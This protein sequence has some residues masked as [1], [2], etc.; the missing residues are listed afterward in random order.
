[1]ENSTEK[2]L[3]KIS[4]QLCCITGKIS[5]EESEVIPPTE[6]IFAPSTS[7]DS[8]GR[9]RVSEPFT[10]FDSSHRFDDNDLWATATATGSTAVFNA[11]QGLVDLNVTAASGSSVVRETIKVFAYQPGKSLLV[12]NT[13]VMA[14]PKTGLTQ[15]VGYYGDDNGFYLDQAD[16]VDVA[17]VKRSVVT[18]SI[19]DTVVLQADWNGDK[20]DG[21]GPSGLTLDLTK[22]QILWMDLEWLGVGSVRMGFVING[23]FILC[24]TFNHANIIASTYITTASLPIRYEIFNTA[25]TSGAST[26]KQ[27]CSTVLSEGGYELRGKQQSIGRSITAPMT[28]AVAGT[29]YPVVGIRLISTRLDAIVIATAISLIG[30]GNGKNYQWRVVN[31]N[32]QIS[33]GSWVP[34][35]GDSAVEYNVTGTSATGGRILASGYV[36]SSNQG[37]PSI[38]ILKEALFSNQLERDALNGVPYELVVEMAID[39]VGGVLGAYASIDWEEISR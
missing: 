7:Q 11:N 36:N 8:F 29:Y 15:R 2:Y 10:M 33:G 28:F 35:G 38:N 34:A 20:L 1:M 22:A 18:G 26:L 19:I 3:R 27:I 6:I 24:H 21:S 31:G 23:Q 12:L 32:V 39:T 30:L 9:L 37:S 5:D 16:N 13:F 17:F 25:G 14:P 4:K